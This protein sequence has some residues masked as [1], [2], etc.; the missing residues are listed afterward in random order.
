[1]VLLTVN[2]LEAACYDDILF[3]LFVHYGSMFVLQINYM[4]KL[5]EKFQSVCNYVY[6]DFCLLK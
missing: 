2:S 5:L 3:Y 6:G 4:T 1:M